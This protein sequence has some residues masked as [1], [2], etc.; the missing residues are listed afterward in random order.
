V[1]AALALIVPAEASAGRPK[2]NGKFE[3]ERGRMRY[4]ETIRSRHRFVVHHDQGAG[5][6]STS[7]RSGKLLRKGL[8]R[9]I[10]RTAG[11][12]TESWGSYFREGPL[13]VAHSESGGDHVIVMPG[14]VREQISRD[15][16][17][18]AA[19]AETRTTVTGVHGTRVEGTRAGRSYHG[20]DPRDRKVGRPGMLGRKRKVLVLPDGASSADLVERQSFLERHSS[21]ILG[22][23]VQVGH[24]QTERGGGVVVSRETAT[25]LPR[26]ISR[27][28]TIDP[29][30]VSTSRGKV[31]KHGRVVRRDRVRVTDRDGHRVEELLRPN[32]RVRKRIETWA[33]HDHVTTTVITRY[34]RSGTPWMTTTLRTDLDGKTTRERVLYRRDGVTPRPPL[35]ER[36]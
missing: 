6:V 4:R 16:I 22:E 18:G 20:L 14:L 17:V 31:E 21:S 5:D 3:V 29:G 9:S 34:R 12:G 8:K 2:R 27:M 15:P 26:R 24:E 35:F 1:V 33:G 13:G 7:V 30:G 25:S 19:I 23:T 36:R 28:T 32:G 11:G 10:A